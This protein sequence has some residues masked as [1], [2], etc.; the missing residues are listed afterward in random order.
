MEVEESLRKSYCPDASGVAGWRL[1]MSCSALDLAQVEIE[2][3][4]SRVIPVFFVACPQKEWQ[5]LRG[6]DYQLAVMHQ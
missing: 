1:M 3:G 4:Q 5:A 6:R 2:Q